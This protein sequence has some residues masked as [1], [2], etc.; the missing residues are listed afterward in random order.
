MVSRIFLT[1]GVKKKGW[2]PTICILYHLS[3][4]ILNVD[5]EV[6]GTLRIHSGVWLGGSVGR[7]SWAKQVG[8]KEGSDEGGGGGGDRKQ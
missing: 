2:T 3:Q 6:L 1:N 4:Q 8:G 5:G 7:L